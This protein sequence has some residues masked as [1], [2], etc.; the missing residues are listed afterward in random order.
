MDWENSNVDVND[1]DEM[2]CFNKILQTI[3]Q[4]DGGRRIAVIELIQL[5][6]A[7][8]T[9]ISENSQLPGDEIESILGRYGLRVAWPDLAIANSSTNLQSLLRDTPWAGTAFRQALRRL[10]HATVA[11]SPLRFKGM[12]TSR[13]TMV[14][15]ETLE[16]L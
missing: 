9:Y 11:N 7:G 1:A 3:L 13:A 15:I 8:K 14:P 6:A 10:P 4:L 12:G 2:R 16:I 5:A